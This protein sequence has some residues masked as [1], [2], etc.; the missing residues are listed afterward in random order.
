MNETINRIQASLDRKRERMPNTVEFVRPDDEMS[1]EQQANW[2]VHLLQKTYHHHAITDRQEALKQS[3]ETGSTRCFFAHENGQV[4][5]VAALIAQPDGAWEL[6]RA[7]ASTQRRGIGG[8]VMLSAAIEHLRLKSSP[9]VAEVRVSQ[10]F[11]G[12]PGGAATQKICLRDIGL[13]PHALLPLFGH[14]DPQRQEQFLLSASKLELNGKPISAPM[15]KGVTNVLREHISLLGNQR[16]FQ[17]ESETSQSDLRFNGWEVVQQEPFTILRPSAGFATLE[18]ATSEAFSQAACCLIPIEARPDRH[19]QMTDLLNHGFVPCGIDRVTGTEG[20]P[21][22]QFARLRPGT[23]LA[24]LGLVETLFNQQQ[25]AALR[26]ID[27]AIRK[28]ANS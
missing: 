28:G 22:V 16:G 9:L 27:K 19:V 7:A 24:P 18:T 2:M 10:V 21:M 3:I 8:V 25:I 6:G 23:A 5:A 20:E 14:G 17:V 26:A 11:E 4:L 13:Q 12:I 1:A 15:S